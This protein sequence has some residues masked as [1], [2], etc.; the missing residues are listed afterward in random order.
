MVTACDVDV[1]FIG[2]VE[3][4][5]IP[6]EVRHEWSMLRKDGIHSVR[7]PASQKHSQVGQAGVGVVR[8]K[9]A[10]VSLPTFA[11]SQFQALFTREAGLFGRFLPIGKGE[12]CA[13]GGCIWVS[14]CQP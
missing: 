4:R 9:G 14:G 10:L 5:L 13:C 3:C 7:F 8:L 11:A 12:V 1:D 2:A 6:G